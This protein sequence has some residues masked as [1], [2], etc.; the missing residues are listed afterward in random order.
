MH[1]LLRELTGDLPDEFIASGSWL[2]EVAT[3]WRIK[4]ADAETD[5]ELRLRICSSRLEQRIQTSLASVFLDRR[6]STNK[7]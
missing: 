2:D 5:D 1:Y 6:Y 4:R 7:G 3:R